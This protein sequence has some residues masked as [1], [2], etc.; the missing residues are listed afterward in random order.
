MSHRLS[1]LCLLFLIPSL[2][3]AHGGHENAIISGLIHPILGIDHN[4]AILASGFLGYSLDKK[5]WFLAPITFIS[6]M[7]IGGFLGVENQANFFVEKIISF[8]VFAL[9]LLITFRLRLPILLIFVFLF[10][11]GFFH[12]YAHGAEMS[13]SQNLFI[14]ILGYTLGSMLLGGLGALLGKIILDKKLFSHSYC[15]FVG[16]IVTGCGIMMLIG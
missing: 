4:I 7:I 6:A 15:R 8:S 11:F 13:E 16:G 1:S 10:V 3:L 2:V 14:Y 5:R 9:G 12:G